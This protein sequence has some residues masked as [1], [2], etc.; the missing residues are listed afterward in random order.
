MFREGKQGDN[1]NYLDRL[2][3]SI[4]LARKK[5]TDNPSDEG[6]FTLLI[7]LNLERE[8]FEKDS[9]EDPPTEFYKITEHLLKMLRERGYA[10]NDIRELLEDSSKYFSKNPTDEEIRNAIGSVSD[11]IFWRRLP[12]KKVAEEEHRVRKAGRISRSILGNL[13]PLQRKKNLVKGEWDPIGH[14]DAKRADRIMDA[15][16]VKHR[17]SGAERS[18]QVRKE[19]VEKLHEVETVLERGKI[20]FDVC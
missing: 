18:D 20:L 1:E 17:I 19:L 8:R 3:T 15:V 14:A 13:D 12:N 11:L 9:K 10:E 5:A 2:T 6:I 7:G 4:E 16:M